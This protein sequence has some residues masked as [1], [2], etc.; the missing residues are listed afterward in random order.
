MEEQASSRGGGGAGKWIAACCG[1]LLL[2]GLLV[3]G[4]A[5]LGFM[6]VKGVID[7][8]DAEATSFLAAAEAGDIEGAYGHFSGPLQQAQPLDDFRAGV[9]SNPDLFAAQDVSF[10]SIHTDA[11]SGVTTLK[12]TVTSKSGKVRH[13][14]FAWVEEGGLKR[15]VEYRISDSPL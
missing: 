6:R 9:Q 11:M 2:V 8:Y 14:L 13:C 4:V 1:C 15:L 3:G 12:G 7:A 10:T 5:A